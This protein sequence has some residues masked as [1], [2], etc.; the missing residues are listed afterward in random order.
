MPHQCAKLTACL[1]K[2]SHHYK[3]VND[4]AQLI[5]KFVDIEPVCHMKHQTQNFITRTVQ[6]LNDDDLGRCKLKKNKF[7][8]GLGFVPHLVN[9]THMFLNSLHH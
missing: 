3:N 7:I 8:D 9:H 1:F 2:D 5:K 6:E 4:D